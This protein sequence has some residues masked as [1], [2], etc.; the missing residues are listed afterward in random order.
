MVICK[1]KSYAT[2]TKAVSVTIVARMNGPSILG[3]L[4][5]SSFGITPPGAWSIFGHHTFTVET[6]TK[7]IIEYKLPVLTRGCVQGITCMVS[8]F[9][10]VTLSVVSTS[11]RK[12]I[13]TIHEETCVRLSPDCL[14]IE[15]I[16]NIV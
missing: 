4:I 2:P 10:Q 14:W 5:A 11:N 6:R 8:G 15:S 1:F 13:L 7:G 9:Y 12:N 16:R 3:S